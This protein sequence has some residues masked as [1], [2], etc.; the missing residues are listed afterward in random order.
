MYIV[1]NVPNYKSF[2]VFLFPEMK[3]CR[4]LDHIPPRFYYPFLTLIIGASLGFSQNQPDYYYLDGHFRTTQKEFMHAVESQITLSSFDL[5][6]QLGYVFSHKS[7]EYRAG[8]GYGINR[9][10]FQQRFAPQFYIG[11]SYDCIRDTRWIFGPV[12]TYSLAGFTYYKAAKAKV[13]Y[14]DFFAGVQMYYGKKWKV[15]TRLLAGASSE[16]LLKSPQRRSNWSFNYSAEIGVRY[17]F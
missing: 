13:L 8:I 17:A 2:F 9:T 15:G 14:H 5:Y 7:F 16:Q 4:M 12:F 6:H 11:A 10:L 3:M 1:K